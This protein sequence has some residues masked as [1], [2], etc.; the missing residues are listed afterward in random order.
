ML[1]EAPDISVRTEVG[2]EP[3]L[4]QGLVEGRLDIAVMYTP[5]SRPGLKVEALFDEQARLRFNRG[6]A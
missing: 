5:E 3:E 2:L 1:K 4:M 6:G